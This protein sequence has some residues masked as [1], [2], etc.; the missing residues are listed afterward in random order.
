M[1]GRAARSPSLAKPIAPLGCLVGA[2][3]TESQRRQTTTT[4][5]HDDTGDSLRES[6]SHNQLLFSV[7]T[8]LQ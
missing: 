4:V 6:D 3:P 1:G 2:S 8:G 7:R 5:D